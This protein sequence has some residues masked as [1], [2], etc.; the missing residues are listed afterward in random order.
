MDCE[1]L[2]VKNVFQKKYKV[3]DFKKK[4]R[5]AIGRHAF[6]PIKFCVSIHGAITNNVFGLFYHHFFRQF[7]LAD[8]HLDYIDALRPSCGEN[9]LGA[10]NH[11]C[12]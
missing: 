12:R 1:G 2:K 11:Y 8:G 6:I 3:Y 7:L 5:P 4:C 9:C 10:T